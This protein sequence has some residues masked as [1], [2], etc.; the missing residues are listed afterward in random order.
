MTTNDP[1]LSDHVRW[2]QFRHS[3][4]GQLLAAPPKRGELRCELEKLAARQW[5]HPLTGDP[6]SFSFATVERWYY[7]ARNAGA[8]PVGA[9]RKRARSDIG[10]RRS[11]PPQLHEKLLAQYKAHRSWSYQLHHDNLTALVE[12][13]PSFGPMPSYA[14]VRRAMKA[15]GLI[16]TNRRRRKSAAAD[17]AQHRKD[18]YEVRSYE[19]E[20]VGGLWHFDFHEGSLPILTPRGEW[21]KP[22]LFG[23]TDDHSRLACHAQWYLAENAENCVHGLIQAILKRGLPRAT[24]SDNGGAETAAETVQGLER[25]GSTP[26]NTLAYAA[27][28]NAKQE[29]WWGQVE[30]RLLPMLEG[31]EELTLELLNRATLAWVEREYNRTEHTEIGVAPMERFLSAPNVMRP[32]PSLDELRIAFAQQV[33]RKQRRG[34]GTV[35]IEGRRFEVP[36]QFRHLEHVTVR[37]ARWDLGHVH[38]IDRTTDQAICRLFPLDKAKNAD[39]RRRLLEVTNPLVDQEPAAPGVAPLLEQYMAD[40]AATGLPPA[41]IPKDDF[42]D[43]DR[44]NQP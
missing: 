25:L 36:A 14:T 30:G 29:V 5:Q 12:A 34:D 33:G 4:V 31:V 21:V 19:V 1:D 42:T 8:D 23:C 9:L 40:Y 22:W 2:A 28:Q 10:R 24:L 39:G 16:K 43:P 27:Y 35:S 26:Q 7:A 17:E 41:F 15:D 6:V 32:A 37:Y 18:A 38:M 20:H 13:D 11:F 3:V 44:E